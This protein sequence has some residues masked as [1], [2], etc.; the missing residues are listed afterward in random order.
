MKIELKTP[1]EYQM[2][3]GQQTEL[4]THVPD[5]DYDALTTY[6]YHCQQESLEAAAKITESNGNV[7][8]AEQIRQ[9]AEQL[10]KT[11]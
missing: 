7:Y 9:Y 8:G 1:E 2:A 4:T 6:F 11:K 5:K 10:R 3:W